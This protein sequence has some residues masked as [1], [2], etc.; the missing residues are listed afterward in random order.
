MRAA[1]R[2][3]AAVLAVALLAGCAAHTHVI[4]AGAQG[5]Q[6]AEQRQWYVLWGLVP[7]NIVDTAAM[8][9]GAHDYTIHTETSV[10]DFVINIF[11]S[12][13]TV[14]SRTVTVTK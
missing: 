9:G 4:G 8:S 10:L 13:V 5:T 2:V 11:T 1:V 12:I 14:N 7:I 3:I 6:T